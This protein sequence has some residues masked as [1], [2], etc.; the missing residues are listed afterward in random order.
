MTDN[1]L[2][3]ELLDGLD[4]PYGL[5][6]TG[7]S[8]DIFTLKHVKHSS[9]KKQQRAKPVNVERAVANEEH[10]QSLFDTVKLAREQ[11]RQFKPVT[12][13]SKAVYV[14]SVLVLHGMVGVVT[15]VG[16]VS[17]KDKQERIEI[18]YD[19][20]TKSNMYK[21]SLVSALSKDKLA[22]ILV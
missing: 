22:R 6:A 17:E 21:A 20:G 11:G 18:V 2:L 16:I 4:D 1:E 8:D 10:D 19:N 9:E 7:E 13:P 5:L 12:S 3:N 15:K 14:S